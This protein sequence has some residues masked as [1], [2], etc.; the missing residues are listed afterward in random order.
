M[1]MFL[2]FGVLALALS[3]CTEE[4]DTGTGIND[5]VV[6]EAGPRVAQCAAPAVTLAQSATRLSSAGVSVHRS[7]CGIIEGVA[8]ATV[9]GAGT[10]E[11]LLHDIPI[12]QLAGAEAAGFQSA[13]R[14]NAWSRAS[15]PIYLHA[16]DV[17][18]STTSCVE[19]RNRVLYIQTAT[20]GERLVLL[21]QA[22]NCADASYRQALYGDPGNT[23]LCSNADSIAGPQKSC[24]VSSRA[25]LFDT[26]LANLNQ[27]NLGLSSGYM[28]T[29]VFPAN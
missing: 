28:V 25:A 19:I 21:D 8:M 11:V 18:R 13:G 2:M 9:C 17:A 15:C 23:L 7:S 3:A 24:P 1:R 20:A 12:S 6:Y 5:V 27:P 26:I 16:I 29:Q 14:L 22:G 10:S 4:G